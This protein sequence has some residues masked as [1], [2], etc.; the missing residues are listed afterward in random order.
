M[1]VLSSFESF[2]SC[3]VPAEMGWVLEADCRL[4]SSA[5]WTDSGADPH[6]EVKR[7]R[8]AGSGPSQNGTAAQRNSRFGDEARALT[9]PLLMVYVYCCASAKA[10]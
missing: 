3:L 2:S 8:L 9:L 5:A 1:E 7:M 4:S 6:S 10:D